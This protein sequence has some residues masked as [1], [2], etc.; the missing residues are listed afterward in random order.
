MWWAGVGQVEFAASSLGE[1]KVVVLPPRSGSTPATI[2][3]AAAWLRRAA[4]K[5]LGNRNILAMLESASKLR[6]PA[7]L[8]G[9]H[10]DLHEEYCRDCRRW[11]TPILRRLHAAPRGLTE[12]RS[13]VV[14]AQQRGFES[15]DLSPGAAWTWCFGQR[16][17]A[18]KLVTGEGGETSAWR[19]RGGASRRRRGKF[20]AGPTVALMGT[21][22]D[23]RRVEW[24][25]CNHCQRPS[26][27]LFGVALRVH[28]SAPVSQGFGPEPEPVA[29]SHGHASCRNSVSEYGPG[30]KPCAQCWNPPTD[31]LVTA[32]LFSFQSSRIVAWSDDGLTRCLLLLVLTMR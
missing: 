29:V 10:M 28:C 17:T 21:G 15:D 8:G 30:S 32:A 14:Q 6:L 11:N 3:F 7:H 1:E 13:T 5:E 25:Q 9:L 18:S 26:R 22:D 19:R 27:Y 31:S 12:A 20:L 23:H 16:E 2:R 24:V 4:S